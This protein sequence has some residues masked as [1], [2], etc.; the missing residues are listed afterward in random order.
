[1]RGKR[2]H[3]YYYLLFYINGDQ[4]I[5]YSMITLM[6]TFMLKSLNIYYLMGYKALALL[7]RSRKY[8][9][10]LY[11]YMTKSWGKL[12]EVGLIRYP[13]GVHKSYNESEMLFDMIWVGVHDSTSRK[14]WR[15]MVAF[16]SLFF[17]SSFL[18]DS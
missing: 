14:V 10:Y 12:H 13:I 4:A 18:Q 17:S 2:A 15:S 7:K 5:I 11:L 1:M 3:Y 6:L 9:L 8:I 16:S